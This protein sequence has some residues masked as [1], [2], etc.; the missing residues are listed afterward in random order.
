MYG[1]EVSPRFSAEEEGCDSPGQSWWAGR[2][3]KTVTVDRGEESPAAPIP[4]GAALAPPPR[5]SLLSNRSP[6]R[7]ET[8]SPRPERGGVPRPQA[9]WRRNRS[10][11]LRPSA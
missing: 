11:R 3:A 7:L 5:P 2:R 8:L 9:A 6:R 4:P 10:A 1:R